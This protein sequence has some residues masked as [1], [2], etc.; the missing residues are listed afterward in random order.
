MTYFTLNETTFKERL[1]T[2]V[3][4]HITHKLTVIVI[5][6]THYKTVLIEN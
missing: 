5:Y 6:Q 2:L 4:F 1:I 3:S